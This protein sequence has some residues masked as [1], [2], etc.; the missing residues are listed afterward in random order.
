MKVEKLIG[1]ANQIAGFFR[2][3]P[4]DQAIS[5]ISDHLAAFWTPNMR[6]ALLARAKQ[7]GGGL[8]PLVTRA[9]LSI[10]TARDSIKKE[11]AGPEEVGNLGRDAG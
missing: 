10:E 8:D 3:Y 11:V 6:A 5:G 7:E 9:L 4:E 1:M 2:S